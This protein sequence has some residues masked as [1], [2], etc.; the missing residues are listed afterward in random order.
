MEF[1]MTEKKIYTRV[2]IGMLLCLA[3]GLILS[4][5]PS[6]AYSIHD[7]GWDGPG[8]GSASLTYYFGNLTSDLPEATVKSTL[9]DALNVWA[10][11][12]D[13]TFTETLTPGLNDSIDFLFATGAHGD[14]NPFDGPG[15][16]VAH[17]FFSSSSNPEPIA[18]DVHFDDAELWEV[19]NGLGASAFDL[20]WVAVHEIGHALG[21]GHSAVS[22][23]VMF[24]SL[25]GNT[26][27]NQLTPDDIAG[28]QSIY[29]QATAVPEPAALLLFGIG[30]A[31]LFRLK[32]RKR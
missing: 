17:S 19:G 4:A 11:V 25:S 10:S 1:V 12:V 14:G 29:G 20:M 7:D 18:G 8:L 22:S 24:P 26:V 5:K 28:I 21:L 23:A 32:L 3:I 15:G 16:V 30:F 13:I 9:V 27:F 31:G 2:Q 6:L